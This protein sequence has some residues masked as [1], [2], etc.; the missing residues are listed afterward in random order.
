MALLVMDGLDAGDAFLKWPLTSGGSTSTTTRFNSGRS[1]LLNNTV[2][3]LSRN[4]TP[5]ATVFFGAAI[6]PSATEGNLLMTF[7]TDN[8]A[9]LH[10]NIRLTAATTLTLYN[11]NTVLATYTHT[12]AFAGNWFYFEMGGTIADAGGTAIVRI[13]GVTV[14]NFTGDT[15]NGGTSTNIDTVRIQGDNSG[16][17][18]VD[19]VYV[20]DGTGSAPYNTFLGDV[21]VQTLSPTGAGS[22]T[23]WTPDTGSNYARVNELPYS[24]ANYVQSG[25]SGQRDTYAM[26]DV[27]ASAGSILAVQNNVISKKTDAA[28]A[29]IKPALKS[30]ATVY[31]GAAANLSS[32]DAVYSDLRT[33]DPNTSTAW[34]QAGV[35]AIESGVEVV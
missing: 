29:A 13:D 14:I 23:Q 2:Y 22:S 5:S 30:G 27:T 18:Y 1:W 28:V 6:R 31:Y 4:I 19:D 10:L 35:N 33:T 12:T 24:A 7:L 20:C 17:K 11:N 16:G 21:R 9:T 8:A 25:T 15:R 26:A 3:Y 32:N 34:T